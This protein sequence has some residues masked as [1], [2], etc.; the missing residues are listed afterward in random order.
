MSIK[1]TKDTSFLST[2]Y[3]YDLIWVVAP[4]L[5]TTAR[6]KDKNLKGRAVTDSNVIPIF[7]EILETEMISM[8][9]QM[10]CY[11]FIRTR[12]EET[13]K[14]R[15]CFTKNMVKYQVYTLSK[16]NTTQEGIIEDFIF[17]SR[18]EPMLI[19]WLFVLKLTYSISDHTSSKGKK[20]T[21]KI[22]IVWED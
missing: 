18:A 8:K 21:Y 19:G 4:L 16:L 13:I 6:R 14:D 7:S 17:K 12:G 2:H 1:S 5:L 9:C 3:Y 22:L 11:L 20:S 10:W 15:V